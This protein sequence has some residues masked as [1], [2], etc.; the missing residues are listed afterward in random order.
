MIGRTNVRYAVLFVSS[1]Q[2]YKLL[3]IKFSTLVALLLTACICDDHDMEL[4]NV[5]PKYV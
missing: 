2:L 1:G 3:L 5:T 4:S